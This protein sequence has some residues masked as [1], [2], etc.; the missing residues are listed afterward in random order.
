MTY[1]GKAIAAAILLT[2]EGHVP[3]ERTAALMAM[4]LGAPVSIG[5]AAPDTHCAPVG[6]SRH[7]VTVRATWQ[8]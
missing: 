6:K 2:S 3:T 5:F 8:K 1:G 7:G 4:A